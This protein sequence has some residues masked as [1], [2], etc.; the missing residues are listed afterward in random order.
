MRSAAAFDS[1]PVSPI[2]PTH[3]G[4]S[5][6]AGETDGD[7]TPRIFLYDAY[8]GGIG[9]SAPLWGMQKGLLEKTSALIAG[10]DCETGCPMC[11]G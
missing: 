5:V 4:L 7:D 2:G 11:V 3:I 1:G 9:F 8:P 10:C 6:N